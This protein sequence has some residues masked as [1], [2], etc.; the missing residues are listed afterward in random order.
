M[1]DK[2]L[3]GLRGIAA[4]GVVLFHAHY[5]KWFEWMWTFVDL[6]F[7]L[8]GF[9]ITRIVIEALESGSFSLKNFM[10]RRVLR[11]WPVYYT[12]LLMC[13]L[14]VVVNYLQN[15]Q[16]EHVSGVKAAPF[17]LQ[18]THHYFSPGLNAGSEKFIIWF[19]HSWSIAVEE[20]FYLFMPLLLIAM[21]KR[22][23]YCLVILFLLILIALISRAYGAFHWLLVSRMDA[24][25]V[26][27][28][29]A[30]Y[31]HFLRRNNIHSFRITPLLA[32]ATA[33]LGLT[34]ITADV[35]PA[36]IPDRYSDALSL[37]GFNL[38]FGC[39]LILLME[40]WLPRLNAFM[41]SEA[42]VFFGSISYALYM[43][44]VPIRGMLLFVTDND[45]ISDS[46]TWVH[47]AY[48]SVS[49]LVAYLSKILLE[50]RMD[51][52]KYKFPVSTSTRNSDVQYGKE[53]DIPPV[54][55]TAST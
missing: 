45:K 16:W 21:R 15:G 28:I 33:L 47:I 40:G 41:S 50:N 4:L 1:R 52:L 53:I 26:G 6:F 31:W 2:P 18:Y 42:M 39:L 11:I 27:A 32:L 5:T 20:Q 17:F 29:V 38:I 22:L 44:H 48:F 7:V 35:L 12:V 34:L 25:C 8:S 37:F 30:F 54:T 36:K 55:Q 14:A 49:I 43:I 13:I 9:L 46:A 3:D 19:H 24:L 10:I 23:S 51:K